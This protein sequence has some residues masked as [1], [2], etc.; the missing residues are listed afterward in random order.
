MLK[1]TGS[2]EFQDLPLT[3]VATLRETSK[4][5]TKSDDSEYRLV[6]GSGG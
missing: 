4:H 6:G 2:Q 1:A 5:L 3:V